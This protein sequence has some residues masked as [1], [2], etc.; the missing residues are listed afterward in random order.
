MYID[1]IKHNTDLLECNKTNFSFV[2]FNIELY[3]NASKKQVLPIVE[4]KNGIIWRTKVLLSFFSWTLLNK[5]NPP[6]KTKKTKTK[7]KQTNKNRSS[8]GQSA[9]TFCQ[10]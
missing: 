8:K 7:Q 6:P 5:T 4:C 10:A 3:V 9:N 2:S 1:N